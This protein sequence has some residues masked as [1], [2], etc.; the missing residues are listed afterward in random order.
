MLGKMGHFGGMSGCFVAALGAP[1]A[2]DGEIT[3]LRCEWVSMMKE[4]VAGVGICGSMTSVK[5]FE[6]MLGKMLHFGEYVDSWLIPLTQQT[7]NGC[8]KKLIMTLGFYA[9]HYFMHFV[10]KLLYPIF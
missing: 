4:N 1:G 6:D 10:I 9:I 5:P 3:P 8:P 7:N 2:L